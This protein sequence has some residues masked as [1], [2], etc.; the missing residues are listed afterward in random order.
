MKRFI[1]R[2]NSASKMKENNEDEHSKT[3]AV[4]VAHPDDET[5]WAG[6]TLLSKPFWNCFIISLCRGNDPDRA[7][8]FSKVLSQLNAQ[9]KMG[10][11]D[12]GPEQYPLAEKEVEETILKLLP[13]KNYDLI[14]THNPSGEYTRHIRHEETSKA[15]IDLWDKGEITTNKLWTFA[16]EDGN[17]AYLPKAIASATIFTPLTPTIWQTK[18]KIITEIYG[19][20]K[21]SWEAQVTPKEEAFWTFNNSIEAERWLDKG[22][23]ES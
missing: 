8:K 16:Y 12:D 13:V 3:V 21:N 2:L 10:N 9:G 11:L 6:G 14:I 15:V 18:Y 19:F 5:L 22:G 20:N 23:I 4:I 7:P 1:I 17:K